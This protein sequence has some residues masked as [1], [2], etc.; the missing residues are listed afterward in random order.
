MIYKLAQVAERFAESVCVLQE[1][2]A[3]MQAMERLL[4]EQDAKLAG[5][6]VRLACHSV[7]AVTASVAH[8]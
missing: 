3:T 1:Q 5:A 7:E 2:K 8:A 6:L 4:K